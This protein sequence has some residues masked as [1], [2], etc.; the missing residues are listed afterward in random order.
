MWR[1]TSTYCAP[2]PDLVAWK[3]CATREASVSLPA[4]CAMAVSPPEVRARLP[5]VE[6]HAGPGDDKAWYSSSDRPLGCASLNSDGALSK[7]GR[8]N[9]HASPTPEEA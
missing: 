1:L 2:A 8:F 4:A 6:C 5:G 7:A 3:N 9:F